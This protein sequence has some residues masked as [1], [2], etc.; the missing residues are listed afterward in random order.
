M[1]WTG[2]DD[3]HADCRVAAAMR[4]RQSAGALQR[5]L[6]EEEAAMG[7]LQRDKDRFEQRARLEEQARPHRACLCVQGIALGPRK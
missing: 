1:T 4:M 5:K 2:G 6:E 3:Q 7:E